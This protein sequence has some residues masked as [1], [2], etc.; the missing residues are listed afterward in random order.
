MK[1]SDPPFLAFCPGAT[2]RAGA[3]T[4]PAAVMGSR[5]VSWDEWFT[6]WRFVGLLFVLIFA[7]YPDVLLGANTFFYR[8]YGLFG[9]P[10]AHYQRVMRIS[11]LDP[12]MGAF[13]AS[14]SIRRGQTGGASPARTGARFHSDRIPEC[15]PD[16]GPWAP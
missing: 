10:L 16:Q 15:F 3:P 7:A 5:T 12:S 8:D 2:V 14:R 4:S 1:N 6:P 13:I 9:Y 11:P